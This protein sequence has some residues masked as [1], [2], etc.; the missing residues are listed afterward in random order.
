MRN[1]LEIETGLLALAGVQEGLQLT[2]VKSL[3][4]SIKTA[5]RTK[6]RKQLEM[7]K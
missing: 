3:Q 6:F 5:E 4:K 7:V 1:L 2:K